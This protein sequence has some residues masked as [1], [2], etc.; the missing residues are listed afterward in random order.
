MTKQEWLAGAVS[1]TD[2]PPHMAEALDGVPVKSAYVFGDGAW[3]VELPNGEYWT[4]AGNAETFQ[5]TFED[6]ADWLW[7]NWSSD[8]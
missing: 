4:L 8:G 7:R 5:R 2:Y 3:L 6:C 1:V